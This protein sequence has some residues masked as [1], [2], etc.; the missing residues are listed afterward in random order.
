MCTSEKLRSI[1]IGTDSIWFCH[2]PARS[3]CSCEKLKKTV[4]PIFRR[5]NVRWCAGKGNGMKNHNKKQKENSTSVSSFVVVA[6]FPK[7]KKVIEY[8]SSIYSRW[9]PTPVRIRC[10]HDCYAQC[11]FNCVRDHFSRWYRKIHFS[12]LADGPF[13]LE[14][15][16]TCT[17]FSS[18]PRILSHAVCFSVNR[19]SFSRFSPLPTPW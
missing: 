7:L 10:A 4:F 16:F 18:L 14:A 9:K 13:T 3:L 5:K 12:T 11:G 17:R 6:V 15:L 2:V 19:K 8:Q 1:F